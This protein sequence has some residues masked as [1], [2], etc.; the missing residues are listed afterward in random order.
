V[1]KSDP[2]CRRLRVSEV[3]LSTALR[4]GGEGQAVS[5]LG[6]GDAHAAASIARTAA[7][8]RPALAEL[9]EA[10]AAAASLRLSAKVSCDENRHWP[11]FC[12]ALEA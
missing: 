3:S 10:R 7:F 6:A 11:L 1:H 9:T 2:V 12:A 4:R 8:N 5:R